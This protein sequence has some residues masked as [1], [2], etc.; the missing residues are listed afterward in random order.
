MK[1]QYCNKYEGTES[2]TDSETIQEIMICVKCK[3][4][5]DWETEMTIQELN[6]REIK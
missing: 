3:S 6:S 5:V 4:K 1:C 2:I